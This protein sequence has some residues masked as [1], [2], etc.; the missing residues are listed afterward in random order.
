MNVGGDHS[1]IG[2][3]LIAYKLQT[4]PE[5]FQIR[6]GESSIGWIQTAGFVAWSCILKHEH[7]HDQGPDSSQPAISSTLNNPSAIPAAAHPATCKFGFQATAVT[8]VFSSYIVVYKI[9]F[10]A[11]DE[12][13]PITF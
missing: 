10:R 13:A 6:L 7:H 9:P 12:G 11:F 8:A 3:V 1:R 4:A 5:V 2:F